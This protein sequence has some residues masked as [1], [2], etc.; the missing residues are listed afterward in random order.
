MK[1]I[2]GVGGKRRAKTLHYICLSLIAQLNGRASHAQIHTGCAAQFY[3]STGISISEFGALEWVTARTLPTIHTI[4][5]KN[6]H[7]KFQI[8]FHLLH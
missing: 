5:Q 3:T 6:F 4:F 8:S 7:P 1:Q 2:D